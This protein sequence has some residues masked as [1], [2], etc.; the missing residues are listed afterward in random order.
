[1]LWNMYCVHS[2][3]V[4]DEAVVFSAGLYVPRYS[5]TGIFS[6][7]FQPF[8]LSE[9]ASSHLPRVGMPCLRGSRQRC[10]SPISGQCL[11]TLNHCPLMKIPSVD[12]NPQALMF[13]YAYRMNVDAFGAQ[14]TVLAAGCKGTVGDGS[15]YFDEFLKYISPKWTGSTTTGTDLKPAIG[16]TATELGAGQYDGVTPQRSLFP[17]DPQMTGN[18][19]KFKVIMTALGDNIKQCR[20][21]LGNNADFVECRKSMVLVQTARKIDQ[22][23]GLIRDLN[24]FITKETAKLGKPKFVSCLQSPLSRCAKVT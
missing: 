13:W 23:S 8:V 7:S 11:G 14:H 10:S 22:A 20:L 15:C 12:R 24:D 2:R 9:Y 17:N 4:L 16:K 1:M 18:P 6:S 19:V 3:A 21:K 5:S